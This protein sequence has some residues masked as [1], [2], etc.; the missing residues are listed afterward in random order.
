MIQQ[1]NL[2]LARAIKNRN[3]FRQGLASETALKRL[4]RRYQ[5]QSIP[6]EIL[7]VHGSPSFHRKLFAAIPDSAALTCI[8]HGL[9]DFRGKQHFDLLF[10][11]PSRH[12][13]NGT[14]H[15]LEDLCFCRMLL[16]PGAFL[17]LPLNGEKSQHMPGQFAAKK[18]REISRLRQAGFMNVTTQKVKPGLSLASGQR[19]AEKF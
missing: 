1:M 13:D 10:Y 12:T 4:F 9:R 3:I 2:L 14:A 16:K 15:L 8:A 18:S 6:F 11:S 5:N 19:P 7:N 17:I